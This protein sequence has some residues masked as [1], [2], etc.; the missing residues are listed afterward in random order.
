MERLHKLLH[1]LDAQQVKILK[2][3]LTSFSTRDPNTMYWELAE[4]LLKSQSKVP[5][6][7]FCA[8]KLY[9][10]KPD[11]R[12]ER[13]K[14][15][16]YSKVLDSLL[17]DIN[18]NRDI[19][20]DELHPIQIR[21]RKKMILFD[22]LKFTPL[23]ETVGMEMIGDIITTSK[24]YEFYPI[25]LDAMY[26]LKWN[27][28][29]KKGIDYFNKINKEI[30]FY[31][32]CKFYSQRA[33][34]LSL[35]MG[36]TATFNSK[37]DKTKYEKFLTDSIQE[38]QLA[39]LE[40]KVSS[41]GYYLK[42]FEMTLLSH[43]KMHREA[44]LVAISMIDYLKQ[45]KNIGRRGRFGVWYGYISQIETELGE[46][47]SALENNMKSREY[48][49]GNPLNIAISKKYELDIRFLQEDYSK[50]MKL[51]DEL[52]Q[53]DTEITGDFRRDMILYYKG[54]IHFNLGEFREAARLFNLKFQLTRD[55]LGWEVNIRFMRIL[56]MIEL[57]KPDEAHS[58]V[59]TVSKHIER[60][61]QINDLTERDKLLLKLFK[62]LAREGFAFTQPSEKTYHLL[63]QLKE[64]GK[65]HSWE[66]LNP[67]LIQIHNWVI[68][69]YG[70]ILPPGSSEL[71][72]VGVK[73]QK[74]RV[75]KD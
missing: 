43:Q 12:L 67:E 47:D 27:Y 46:L 61:Q 10:S 16:L 7:K 3:Y 14:N 42:T 40:T 72:R 2:K 15:R 8:Q 5:S 53:T 18:T 29:L 21:M 31:E 23:K 37:T 51:V 30:E 11:Y 36:Q 74:K 73:K 45:N 50:A 60:Y 49:K 9:D 70:R 22:L 68:K 71:M 17:I 20:E 54:C 26:I 58:M 1:T 25:L 6:L 19:Y 65:P 55:K 39:F 66:P 63:L 44:K 56:T 57:G 38:L 52:A 75:L 64:T 34:D 32:K 59:D 24:Q 28:S 33:L 69:K 4:I 62:E 13:L 35:Q 48:F 41:V